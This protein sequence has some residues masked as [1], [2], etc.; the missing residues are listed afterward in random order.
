[1]RP[2]GAGEVAGLCGG[3]GPLCNSHGSA[4]LTKVRLLLPHVLRRGNVR[5]A[6][7]TAP[8]LCQGDPKWT[9][10]VQYFTE[11]YA[12]SGPCK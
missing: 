5:F 3:G 7:W 12:E 8:D 10:G 11:Q 6:L 1:M 9:C 4:R 2:T